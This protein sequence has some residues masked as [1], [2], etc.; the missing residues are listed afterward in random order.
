MVDMP[1]RRREFERAL[2]VT[3]LALTL[4]LVVG[5]IFGNV[6]A[7]QSPPYPFPPTFPVNNFDFSL[8]TSATLIK[9][10]Q[11]QTGGLVV[12]VNLYCPNSTTNIR[13]D[14]TV[15][16]TVYLSI[17][18]CPGG[19]FCIL[20]RQVVQVPPVSQGASNLIVYTFFG[21]GA[22]SSPVLMT[23]TG[24]DQFGH[25]HSTTFGVVV[26]YC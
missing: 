17:S 5:G 10:Q 23:V 7:Y 8:T 11:G 19:A 22:S 3:F 20:S 1:L 4:V 26:C 18:G 2:T 6:N 24:V 14:S 12:W 16:E 9:I 13:C 25:T 15:L 21:I